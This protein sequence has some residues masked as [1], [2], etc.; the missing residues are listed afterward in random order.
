MSTITAAAVSALATPHLAAVGPFGP[1]WGAGG[2]GWGFPL[3]GLLVPLFWIA[4]IVTLALVFGRRFR[5][6]RLESAG[7]LAE[8]TLGQ[9]YANGDI[10]EREYRARLDVLRATRPTR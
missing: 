7:A 5:R 9:R 10:D 1:G 8:Q 2:P 6:A 4:V 3:L